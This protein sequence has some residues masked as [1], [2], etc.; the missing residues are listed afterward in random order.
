M[1]EAPTST[2]RKPKSQTNTEY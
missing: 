1:S 2:A